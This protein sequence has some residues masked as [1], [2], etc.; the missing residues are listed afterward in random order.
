MRD[1]QSASQYAWAESVPDAVIIVGRDGSIVHANVHA[2]RLFG[3][4]QGKLTRLTIDS[5]IP[6]EHRKRHSQFAEQFFAGPSVRP[7]G[8]G[9]ELRALKSDGREFPVEIAIGP[10]VDREHVVAVV[11]DLTA[12]NRTRDQLRHSEVEAQEELRLSEQRFRL[13]AT[14]SADTMQYVNVQEDRYIW[15][16]DI[17]DLM[18]YEPGKFPRSVS[19]WLKLI[20]PEDADRIEKDVARIV[21][22]GEPDWNLAYRI[23]AKDGSYRYWVDRGTVT[24]F[25]DGRSNEGIGAIVD[26]TE[27]VL[28][29]QKLKDALAEVRLLKNR[30]EAESEYLQEEIK[31]SHNFEEII[32][33]RCV[34]A[35]PGGD[36][37]REG[38]G[39][40]SNSR[41]Q[42]AQQAP[43]DQG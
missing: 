23:R 29:Q 21:E 4:E 26:R 16:T 9:R 38:V 3:C 20:H 32:G 43:A 39:G 27:E 17:D 1:E 36:G 11:R 14:H 24:G 37:V 13:A 22:N 31:S 33:N 41:P 19:G 30:V 7:M 28:A 2:G 18:G 15:H 25:V 5:L 35:D 8:S 40:S 42:R 10:T 6:E 34:G 12:T